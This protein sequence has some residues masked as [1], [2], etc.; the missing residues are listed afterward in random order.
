[1]F[2]SVSFQAADAGRCPRRGSACGTAPRSDDA[3][4]TPG[5]RKAS[6]GS[7][8]GMWGEEAQFTCADEGCGAAPLQDLA[9]HWDDL[10]AAIVA[11]A[12]RL[13]DHAIELGERHVDH[14]AI[15]GIHRF[16]GDDLAEVE[17]LLA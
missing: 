5:E 9:P 7:A 14:A 8:R 10:D 16:K 2:R 12:V 15:S 6:R 3:H 4:S 1:M 17:S 13:G 11:F